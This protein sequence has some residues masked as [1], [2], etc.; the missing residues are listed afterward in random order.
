M[1]GADL[2]SL[3]CEQYSK[4]YSCS[5]RVSLCFYQTVQASVR[6][7]FP[8]ILNKYTSDLLPSLSLNYLVPRLFRL[9][10]V[11]SDHWC[12]NGSIPLSVVHIMPLVFYFSI[13]INFRKQFSKYIVFNVCFVDAV[14]AQG[15]G[16][17]EI[18]RV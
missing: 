13:G 4:G 18:P 14:V 9:L 5:L 15:P 8:V 12:L 2:G 3:R 10:S 11:V 17:Y 1:S 16:H 6:S 7:P